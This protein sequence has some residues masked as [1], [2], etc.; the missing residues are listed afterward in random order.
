[1]RADGLP[2]GLVGGADVAGKGH[3][4]YHLGCGGAEDLVHR[5]QRDTGDEAL[6]ALAD[7]VLR[8]RHGLDDVTCLHVPVAADGR[9]H[10]LR[11]QFELHRDVPGRPVVGDL[12]FVR[13]AVRVPG[14]P[15]HAAG[16][17]RHGLGLARGEGR[18]AA[19]DVGVAHRGLGARFCDLLVVL[20]PRH[21]QRLLP[22][23]LMLPVFGRRGLET[24]LRPRRL[25]LEARGSA[26]EPEQPG[27]LGGREVAPVR[28]GNGHAQRAGI[29]GRRPR[30]GHE[31][32]KAHRRERQNARQH[33][34]ETLDLL[35]HR[36][37][38]LLRGPLLRFEKLLVAGLLPIPFLASEFP[39]QPFV[40]L[41]LRGQAVLPLGSIT[42]AGHVCCAPDRRAYWSIFH[43]QRRLGG[44]PK[45]GRT[46]MVGFAIDPARKA[47]AAS[48]VRTC[49]KTR[50]RFRWPRSL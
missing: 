38:L 11:R 8:A 9:H 4:P 10:V 5:P 35:L 28:T 42:A 37:G 20:G 31:P 50:G 24:T 36:G 46:E 26:Q 44:W 22:L 19:G 25:P 47:M 27:R 48:A 49:A 29:E 16:E 6:V 18:L 14:R 45:I 2:G 13:E 23:R 30:G 12:V 17:P 34:L 32:V 43:A 39:R 21:G 15:E 3:R 33:L 1:V 40:F 41:A 7:L